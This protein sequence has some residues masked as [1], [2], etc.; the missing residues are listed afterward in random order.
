MLRVGQVLKTNMKLLKLP[1]VHI[2]ITKESV[3]DVGSCNGHFGNYPF[4]YR[5]VYQFKLK[6]MSFRLCKKCKDILIKELKK[7]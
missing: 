7:L 3:K 2:L 6:T 1:D 4:S 5:T